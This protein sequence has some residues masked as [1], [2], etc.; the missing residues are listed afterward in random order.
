METVSWCR[1]QAW[2]SSLSFAAEQRLWKSA[3]YYSS[4]IRALGLPLPR[5]ST[6]LNCSVIHKAFFFSKSHFYC[7]LAVACSF[8]ADDH[9][10][11][12]SMSHYWSKH[13]GTLRGRKQHVLFCWR[14]SPTED[15]CWNHS[16]GLSKDLMCIKSLLA[17]HLFFLS[18]R[19][20]FTCEN[21]WIPLTSFYGYRDKRQYAA[22]TLSFLS[23]PRSRRQC[24]GVV[25]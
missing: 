5:S 13:R 7:R 17:I 10:V 19:L 25:W 9:W 16:A 6:Q 3:C 2:W 21:W 4:L 8:V 22:D 14:G 11:W 12:S 24:Q 15:N 20:P 1:S 23:F 18:S